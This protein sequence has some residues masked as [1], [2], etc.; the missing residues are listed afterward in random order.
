MPNDIPLFD[1]IYSLRAM[2]YLS[3]DPVPDDVLAKV[4]EAA[5]QAT[6]ASNRQPWRF[7]VVRDA[8]LRR[9]IAAYYRDSF[10]QIPRPP[11][12]GAPPAE[13]ATMRGVEHLAL[14]FA[15]V[16]VLIMVCYVNAGTGEPPAGPLRYSSIFP[17]VQN[18]M[19]A[20]RAFGLGTVL[21]TLHKRHDA[22][23]K[24]LLAIPE[25]VQTVCLIPLGYAAR[26][27]G[28]LRRRPWREVSYFDRWGG[29]LT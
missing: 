23:V 6:S 24:E 21:T 9:R 29:P 4:L 3:P 14:H 5:T 27:F 13:G 25:D 2:R 16:P 18:L 10:D 7:V 15:D 20:A 28:P 8:E 19:L 12:T 22:E 1:A 26:P 11:A 17:A